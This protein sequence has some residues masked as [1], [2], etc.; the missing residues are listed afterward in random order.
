MSL[1]NELKRRNVLRVGAAY[2][3]ASWLVIQ[4]AETIFPLFGFGDTP[5]RIVVIVMAIGFPLFLVFSWVFE[6]TPDGLKRET[7]VERSA[8]VMHKTGKQLDRI[9]VVLLALALGY[10]AFDKFVLEPAR[11]A[12]LM[13]ETALQARSEALVESYGDKS[14]AVLPFVNMSDD[15]NN[16][17]FSDGISEELLNLLAKI[18]ELRVI[19]RSSTFSF[20]GKGLSVPTIARQLNVRHILEGSVRKAGNQVRITAQLIDARSDTHLWSETYDRKLDNIF[21]IQDEIAAAVVEALKIELLGAAPHARKTDPEAFKRVLQARFFWNRRSPGDEEKAMDYYQ[22][23][24]DIDPGNAAAWTGLSVAYLSLAAKERIPFETGMAKA[25]KA[26]ATALSIDPDFAE[27]H[28]RLAQ[29]YEQVN[30]WKAA[31]HEY[32]QAL[33]LAPNNPLALGTMASFTWKDGYLDEAIDLFRNAEDID[34]LVATWPA[35]T[36]DALIKAGR[37]DEA[38]QAI[39]KARELSPESVFFQDSLILVYFFQGHYNRALELTQALPEDAHK[40]FG[41]TVTY[42][43]MGRFD[44]SDAAM[45][46]LTSS[47]GKHVPLLT[48]TAHAMRNEPDQAFE[49]LVKTLKTRSFRLGEIK[50][51]PFLKN[52]HDDPRWDNLLKQI[53]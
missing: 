27:A 42:H 6:F 31:R 5:A 35:M 16:E 46:Q 44:E 7:E 22:Q 53:E 39:Y 13:E 2:I 1:F 21:Q 43:A 20:K 29:M 4:V 50:F 8:S 11:V 30:D 15:A 32:L 37:F 38:E 25:R 40:V 49:W 10:F 19:S 33:A 41:L 34:P 26:V 45:K 9:F 28:V 47:T 48:A 52:L 23:A 18:P 14:I 51:E 36:A 17:Y 3:V 12:V 24:I